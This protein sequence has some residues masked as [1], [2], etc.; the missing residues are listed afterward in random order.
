MVFGLGLSKIRLWA[1]RDL[2]NKQ[3][4]GKSWVIKPTQTCTKARG[5]MGQSG[6]GFFG[7]SAYVVRAHQWSRAIHRI[8]TRALF[9][10]AL[11]QELFLRITRSD[12]LRRKIRRKIRRPIGRNGPL[13]SPPEQRRPVFDSHQGLGPVIARSLNDPVFVSTSYHHGRSNCFTE[14][15]RLFS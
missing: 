1:C 2:E 3:V 4:V 10:L 9:T 13:E 5:L 14:A 6:P 11:F 12:L 15:E 8:G 7:H